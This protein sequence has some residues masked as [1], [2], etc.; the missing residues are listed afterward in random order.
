MYVWENTCATTHPAAQSLPPNSTSMDA[1]VVG[2]APKKGAR[3]KKKEWIYMKSEKYRQ[4]CSSLQGAIRHEN[5]SARHAIDDA[6]FP[7]HPTHG[8]STGPAH[9]HCGAATVQKRQHSH[10]AHTWPHQHRIH[11][12]TCKHTASWQTCRNPTQP[13][14]AQKDLKWTINIC[15][16]FFHQRGKQPRFLVFQKILRTSHDFAQNH[17]GGALFDVF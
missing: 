15:T 2:L 8:L 12:R 3:K 1:L 11:T 5:K 17:V 14:L 16:H 10:L 4:S 9:P 7:R 13:R 6:S